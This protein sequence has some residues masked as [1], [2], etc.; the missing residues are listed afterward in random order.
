M[1]YNDAPTGALAIGSILGVNG[2]YAG[3]SFNINPGEEVVIGKDS[4]R[5]S[6]VIDQ[7]YKEV[8]RRHVGVAYDASR[9]QYVVTDY[10]SNGTWVDGRKLVPGQRNYCAAGAVLELA[11]K[12]TV[13]KLGAAGA[14]VNQVPPMSPPPMMQQT[15]PPM[16]QQTPPPMQQTPPPMAQP[17]PKG[18]KGLAIASMVCG[19]VALVIGCWL[20]YVTFACSVL[21]VILGSV[22]LAKKNAGKGM[23]IAG[24]VCG[25]VALVPAVFVVVAGA[26]VLS[27]LG[28]MF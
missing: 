10:S 11:D 28:L 25:I 5:C 3:C 7:A 21:A 24:L 17:A 2:T 20:P 8:S 16:M 26:S 1:G 4:S 18:G 13:F 19:I 12:K 27:S 6:I 14:A 9:G 15:P 23:A 22:S